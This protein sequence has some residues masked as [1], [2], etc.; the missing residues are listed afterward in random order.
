LDSFNA[1]ALATILA[2][3]GSNGMMCEHDGYDKGTK[4]IGVMLPTFKGDQS[5][6][7]LWNNESTKEK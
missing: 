4:E 5:G 7:K 6:W 1:K 2:K 3:E